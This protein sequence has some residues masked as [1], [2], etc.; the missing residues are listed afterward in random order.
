[1]RAM[2]RIARVAGI[3]LLFILSIPAGCFCYCEYIWHLARQHEVALQKSVHAELRAG[4]SQAA[5]VAFLKREDATYSII[6]DSTSPHIV[7]M[8]P[9]EHSVPY[10]FESY[11]IT[12]NIDSKGRLISATM[13][14][15]F[16]AI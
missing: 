15:G 13:Q 12:I 3:L 10:F 1:M 14:S 9:E 6:P 7:A 16:I 11:Q 2:N 4:T 5:A 8:V